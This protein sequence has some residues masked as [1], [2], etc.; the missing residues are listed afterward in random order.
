VPRAPWRVSAVRALD[1]YHLRVLFVDGTEGMVDMSGLVQSPEA[2]VFAAFLA[3]YGISGAENVIQGKYGMP[4][5]YAGGEY[6][7]DD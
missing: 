4:N 2:G 7:R 3:K 6:D 5:L 1:R